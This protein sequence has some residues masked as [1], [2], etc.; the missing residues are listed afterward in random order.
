MQICYVTRIFLRVFLLS[1]QPDWPAI[2]IQHYKIGKELGQR[3]ANHGFLLKYLLP[4]SSK[5]CCRDWTILPDFSMESYFRDPIF[6]TSYLTPPSGNIP[7]ILAI[8]QTCTCFNGTV[9][10]E[11]CLKELLGWVLPKLEAELLR[12]HERSRTVLTSEVT[13]THPPQSV[14]PIKHL[15]NILNLFFWLLF[16]PGQKELFQAA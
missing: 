4:A 15:I 6:F 12:A 13:W 3:K 1:A 9:S 2:V 16:P 10:L 11:F 5:P 14:I 8:R 7:Y